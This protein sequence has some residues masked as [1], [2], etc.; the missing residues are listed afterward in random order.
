VYGDGVDWVPVFGN[1]VG[2]ELMF[3]AVSLFTAESADSVAPY[4][5]VTLFF[6]WVYAS[7]FDCTVN[8]VIVWNG[9]LE[10]LKDSSLTSGAFRCSLWIFFLLVVKLRLRL[11]PYSAREIL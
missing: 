9:L 1:R 11:Q 8:L 6:S 2:M 7:W 5:K 3:S 4:T 10:C